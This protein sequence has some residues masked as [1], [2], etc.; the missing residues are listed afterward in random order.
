V[1]AGRRLGRNALLLAP[2]L[3]FLAAALAWTAGD[4]PGLRPG[5]M[6]DRD[7]LP[8]GADARTFAPAGGQVPVVVEGRWDPESEA[9]VRP[10]ARVVV[11]EDPG[12][13]SE[14]RRVRVRLT[15]GEHEGRTARVHRLYL[16][17]AP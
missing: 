2:G 4:W 11:V 5:P 8:A 7:P 9:R 14:Y 10:G 13:G 16:R 1:G 15:A 12:G 6:P 3:V 17:P